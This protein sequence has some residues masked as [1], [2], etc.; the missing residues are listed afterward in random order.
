MDVNQLAMITAAAAVVAA[1]ASVLSL[2]LQQTNYRENRQYK[3]RLRLEERYFK[4]HL[5]L[6]ELRIASVTLQ[7]LPTPSPDFAPQ[8]DGMPVA[9]ITEALATKDLLTPEAATKVRIARDDLVQVEQMA[10]DARS[11]EVRK[12]SG[13][14]RRFSD[15]VLK[16]LASLDE[17]RDALLARLPGS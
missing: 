12:M 3:E 8:V 7:S 5:L 16:A 17:A 11:G 4:L 14:E 6:Q 13:Y 2:I 15:R 1:V 9:Q 10:A